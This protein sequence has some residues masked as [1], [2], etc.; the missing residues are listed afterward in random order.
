MRWLSEGK[1]TYQP[2]NQMEALEGFY[3]AFEDVAADSRRS[4]GLAPIL[5]LSMLACHDQNEYCG[6][7]GPHDRPT[8]GT[9]PL[10]FASSDS[11]EVPLEELP[12]SEMS[13]TIT[14]DQLQVDYLDEASQP[15]SVSYS[16]GE[17]VIG[18]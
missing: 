10:W 16:I 15:A 1:L 3:L 14:G 8:S 5:P 12:F 13:M 7:I 4:R 17:L 6:G 11:G 18:R 2:L 9:Y